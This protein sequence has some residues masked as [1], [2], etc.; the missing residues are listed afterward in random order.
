MAE[1]RHDEV[2]HT[3]RPFGDV[4]REFRGGDAHDELSEA[5]AEVTKAVAA[6]KKK[7]E[8]TL[9][10]TLKPS[11]AAGALTVDAE[12]KTKIPEDREETFFFA[13]DGG[14]LTRRNPN[15]PPLEFGG[16]REVE[17]GDAS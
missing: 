9:K 16:P 14:Y 6:T 13:A 7:G 2:E 12:V 4:L 17:G 1:D 8:L 5:L 10:L 15:Q 3:A 11:K